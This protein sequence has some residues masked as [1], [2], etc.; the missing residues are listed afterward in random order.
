[1]TQ[2]TAR[3]NTES[4]L[5]SAVCQTQ[6]SKCDARV[7]YRE[8]SRSLRK[9]NGGVQA[10]RKMKCLLTMRRVSGCDGL[11]ACLSLIREMVRG[12]GCT[13]W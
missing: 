5:V 11:L 9:Q 4:A 7:R 10:L 12:D 3:T 6:K 13:T 1:M 8:E 2:V